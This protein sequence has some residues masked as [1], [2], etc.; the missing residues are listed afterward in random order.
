MWGHYG[1]KVIGVYSMPFSRVLSPN[2]DLLWWY[3]PFIYG[4][5]C[6]IYFFKQLGLN[7]SIFVLQVSYFQ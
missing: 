7:G 4:R 6:P 2:I 1:S 3:K 5:L